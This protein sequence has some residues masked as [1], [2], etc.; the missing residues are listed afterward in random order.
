[1]TGISGAPRAPAPPPIE[2]DPIECEAARI[3]GA[4]I[5]ISFVLVNRGSPSVSVAVPVEVLG[6]LAPALSAEGQSF[7]RSAL[8]E[9]PPRTAKLEDAEAVRAFAP[10]LR[11]A[12]AGRL[13]ELPGIVEDGGAARLLGAIEIPGAGDP[14]TADIL[15]GR[16]SRLPWSALASGDI[17]GGL[18]A[19]DARGR[20]EV[21]EAQRRRDAIDYAR[22]AARFETALREARESV[23]ARLRAAALRGGE[24]PR[25]SAIELAAA[26]GVAV[27]FP[28][29]AEWNRRGRPWGDGA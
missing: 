18:R 2:T 21:V 11:K 28:P 6:A 22:A 14:L 4:A 20:R 19:L 27:E 26:L 3:E 23:P 1:M 29:V 13:P 7:L 25:L 5:L 24:A 8:R 12:L 15:A 17:A 9:S 10:F 16:I